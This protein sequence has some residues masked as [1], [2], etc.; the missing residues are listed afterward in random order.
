ME[1]TTGR[2]RPG[3]RRAIE[4]FNVVL[5][6]LLGP[7][8]GQGLPH[9]HA[10]VYTATVPTSRGPVSVSVR[11]ADGKRHVEVAAPGEE[12]SVVRIDAGA[13][14]ELVAALRDVQRYLGQRPSCHCSS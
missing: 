8:D 11:R 4:D 5:D 2:P 9:R 3:S 13:A 6:R 7:D 10:A 12:H 14:G 1:T